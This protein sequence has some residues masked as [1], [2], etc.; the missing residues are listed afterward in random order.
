MGCAQFKER[1]ASG[2]FEGGLNTYAYVEGNPINFIDPYGLD[3]MV[4]GGGVRQGSLNFFGHTASAIT[5]YGMASYGNDT[6]L[7][8]SV[9]S[10][11]QS[12]SEVRNQLV[13]ILP[14]SAEQDAA[15]IAYVKNHPDAGISKLNNCAV[16]T[17]NILNAA[18]FR[19]NGVPFPGG[20]GREVKGYPGAQ[21]YFIP[22]GGRI[23]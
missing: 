18:G 17:N 8:S 15:A 3:V 22:Q 5:G 9:A 13:T 21:S 12:Q 19:T 4:I 1:F 6:P 7:G 14:T 23:P 10:Y 11:L 16:Q 2:R 20:L